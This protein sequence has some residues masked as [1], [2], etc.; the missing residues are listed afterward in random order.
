MVNDTDVMLDASIKGLGIGRIVEPMVQELFASNQL[1]PILK[2]YWF[3]YSAL[4]VYFHQN[5][6]KAKRVRVLI[7]FLVVKCSQAYSHPVY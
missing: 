4:Y 6:Q 7:D 1:K 3:P 5:R 2:E